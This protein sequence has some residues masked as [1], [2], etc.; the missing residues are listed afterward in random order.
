V[1]KRFK[2]YNRKL[3]HLRNRA[4][5]RW[6]YEGHI[7]SGRIKE[8]SI[9]KMQRAWL[10]ACS[11]GTE[12]HYLMTGRL[13]GQ[14]SEYKKEFNRTVIKN[15][16]KEKIYKNIRFRE[17]LK[18]FTTVSFLRNFEDFFAKKCPLSA[19]IHRTYVLY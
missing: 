5:L 10:L 11:H 16:I 19:H 7:F 17:R 3:F 6:L 4:L 13:W 9:I 14:R 18:C 2:N 15:C 1:W 8:Q 12:I